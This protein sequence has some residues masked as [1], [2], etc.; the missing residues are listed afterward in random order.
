MVGHKRKSLRLQ[1]YDYS[2]SGAYFVTICVKDRKCL[3]GSVADSE[4]GLSKYSQTTAELWLWLSSAYPYVSLDEWTIMPNH[5]HGI[6]FI[7]QPNAGGSRTAPTM[8][9]PLPLSRLV[10][11]FK[12]ISSKQ[13]NIIRQTPGA[14]FWQRGFYEHIIRDE[15]SLERI[16]EYIVTNPLR[17][18]LDREN[19]Q[20]TGKDDFDGW[21][22]KFHPKP[23]NKDIDL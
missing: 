6:I 23:H 14:P 4:M 11:A 21:L 3:L 9:Q 17:W 15:K 19:P 22:S 18:Q 7:N 16:Q 1:N 13:I 2:Q 5:F 20:A 10:G 8:P 12:T